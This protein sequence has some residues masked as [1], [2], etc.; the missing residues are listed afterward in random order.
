MKNAQENQIQKISEISTSGISESLK[1]EL[2]QTI[3]NSSPSSP[4][5]PELTVKPVKARKAR[6]A[7]P[8]GVKSKNAITLELLRS[9]GTG[10]DE[11][12]QAILT[13]YPDDDK[14]TI[15]RTSQ[16]RLNGEMPLPENSKIISDGELYYL[17]E[18]TEVTEVTD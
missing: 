12:V 2:I 18:V 15:I 9:S 13:S 8:G 4:S 3:L 1:L 5:S 11:V 7:R 14:E 6:Q 17:D 10:L 16:R